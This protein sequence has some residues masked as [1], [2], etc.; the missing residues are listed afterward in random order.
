MLLRGRLG[1]RRQQRLDI[2]GNVN[3]LDLDQAHLILFEPGEEGAGRPVIGHARVFVADCRRIKFEEAAHGVPA[4]AMVTLY[5]S[6]LCIR[7]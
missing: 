1:G 7:A 5:G 6:S 2:S 3:R 4:C